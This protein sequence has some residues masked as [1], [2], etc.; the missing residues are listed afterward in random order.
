MAESEGG[1]KGTVSD[2]VQAGWCVSCGACS[3]ACAHDAIARPLRDGMFPPVVDKAK[4]VAC[5]MCVKVCPGATSDCSKLYSRGIELFGAK[6][7]G[8]YSAFALDGAIRHASAS[9]GVVTA[10]LG[11][12]LRRGTVSRAY[13]VEYE[14]FD[15][16][17]AA[18]KA[19]STADG[20][21]KAARSKYVPVSVEDVVAAVRDGRIGGSAVVCTPCQLLAIRKA[22]DAYGVAEDDVLFIGLFCD[23]MFSYSVYGE[24]ARRFG[25][26]DALHFKDKD[27]GGWP[28]ST[29]LFGN[30]GARV[31]DKSFRMS[32]KE[33]CRVPR[34]DACFDKLNQEAD[35][36]V[37][38]CYV[39]G[40]ETREGMSNVIVRTE[41]GRVAF[42]A[43]K[44]VL[45]VRQCSY[46]AVK[47]SQQFAARERNL[48]KAVEETELLSNVPPRGQVGAG[49]KGGVF[50]V[51]IDVEGF[52][53]RGDQLMLEAAYRQV[54]ARLPGAVIAVPKK[55]YLENP[56]WCMRRRIVPL[57]KFDARAGRRFRQRFNRFLCDRVL[58]RTG[59]VLPD[60]ID[61]VLFAA[62]FNYGD[63]FA[64]WYTAQN[65][66]DEVRYY[67]S[68][69]RPGRRFVLLPQALGPFKTPAAREKMLKL[70]SHVDRVYAREPVSYAH[71]MELVPDAKNVRTVPDFTCLCEPLEPSVRLPEKSYVVIIPNARMVTHTPPEI[72][73]AYAD[74]MAGI[75]KALLEHGEDVVFL[76]HEGRD[77]EV[78]IHELNGRLGNRIPVLSG[79]TGLDC[80]AVIAASKLTVSSR[81][82]G[83]VSGLI[84]GVPT[85]CTSWSH[86]YG[87]LLKEHG[88]PGNVLD[89]LDLD[90]GV[91]SVIDALRHPERY[92]SAPGCIE[93][94]RSRVLD[95]WD[96]IF[97]DLPPAAASCTEPKYRPF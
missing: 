9:G 86:K 79:M 89:V 23:R 55:A 62:G 41:K 71:F 57:L 67:A 76:N 78:Q 38:D 1:V 19:V 56:D 73:G 45:S 75:A 13:V 83:V 95:M 2:V 30:D 16:R 7:V 36:S 65:I 68:F 31:V 12:L 20:L 63:Q 14:T 42:D 37:G 50:R 91:A 44:G 25:R 10:M 88:R 51:L 48:R 80:K 43:A 34:C 97:A 4:C 5:G 22:M 29:I 53:N 58:H 15:G 33:T 93:Q 87:E 81:F 35:I 74:F 60:Q 82:H 27:A 66:E 94:V 59:F 26:F 24:Y 84:E 8:V 77:D 54:R 11:E 72:A 85:L 21:S 64:E 40:L 39:P 3:V 28:G 90:K 6:P 46:E 49:G 70:Y 47:Q 52:Q 18:L 69:T 61:L 96:E 92:A 32:L 17:Q